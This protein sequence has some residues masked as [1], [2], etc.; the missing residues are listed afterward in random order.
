MQL[1]VGII[2]VTFNSQNDIVR[3]LDS[4]LIQEYD[5]LVVYIVDNIST[6]STLSIVENFRS[7]LNITIIKSQMNNGY[8]SGNNIGIRKAIDDECEFVFILNPD[9][10]LQKNCVFSLVKRISMDNNIGVVGP[11]VLYG[12]GGYNIIQD[13]GTK[14]NFKTQKKVD[15][16]GGRKLTNKLPAEIYVDFVN[17]GAMMLRTAILNETGLFEEDYFMYNDELDI[18]YRI[19]KAGYQIL[20]LRDAKVMHFHNYDKQNVN[21]NNFLYYYIMRNKYLYFKKYK[22]YRYLCVSLIKELIITPL[23]IIWALRRMG[24]INVLRFYY[25]GIIDGL[26]NKK[27]RSTKSFN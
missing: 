5:D 17:G 9:M 11:L 4:I 19:K 14:A 7:G 26:F 18:S 6:D 2:I 12:N 13:F 20:C 1:K 15:Y 21:G 16:F 22:F 10:Q 24:N 25:S 8:A 27:G 3:L 23:K